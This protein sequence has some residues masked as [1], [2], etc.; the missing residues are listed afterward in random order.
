MRDTWGRGFCGLLLVL[1]AVMV[2]SCSPR[3]TH[4]RG[5][6]LNPIE[7]LDRSPRIYHVDFEAIADSMETAR[8]VAYLAGGLVGGPG[9][10]AVDTASAEPGSAAGLVQVEY[11]KARRR[12]DAG[13]IGFAVKHLKRALEI[14]PE[15]RPAHLL[16]AEVFLDEHRVNE[17]ASIFGRLLNRDITDSDALVGLARCLMLTGRLDEAKHALIDAVIFDRV[18]LGAWQNL[19]V[20]GEVKNFTVAMHDAP[21][22]GLARKAGGRHYD[23]VVDTSVEDCPVEAAAWIVFASERAV[24][25]YEGKYKQYLGAARYA[26]TYEEDIDCYMALAAAWKT[27]S[28]RDSTSCETDYLDHLDRVADDGYLVLHV[29]FDYVC[30]QDPFAARGFSA[31]TIEG[32][33]EYVNKYVLVPRG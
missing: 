19:H 21:E 14:D 24:W 1:P 25:R 17:A 9:M 16:S 23:L 31:E 2:L 8:A 20:L 12:Y 29:L 22:L 26:R 15:F 27:L 18:N 3:M 5:T 7:I 28:P 11:M 6:S 4:E 32:L 33:R 13:A 30:L 10:A